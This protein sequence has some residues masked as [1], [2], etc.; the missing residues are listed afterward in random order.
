MGQTFLSAL[1]WHL[2]FTRP[3]GFEA[4]GIADHVVHDLDP[5]AGARGSVAGPRRPGWGRS[6][7]SCGPFPGGHEPTL[8]ALAMTAQ[9]SFAP[10]RIRV[11]LRLPRLRQDVKSEVD[12]S[13]F[14]GN[15]RCAS[16]ERSDVQREPNDRVTGGL[17]GLD[18]VAV[19]AFIGIDGHAV[20][21]GDALQAFHVDGATRRGRERR[22]GRS[23]APD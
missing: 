2:W 18:A 16:E 6:G 13:A 17:D 7:P 5:G 1:F 23:V 12:L 11:P 3:D 21:G 20:S 10:V 4:D 9:S 19:G 22:F 8:D 14:R 15:N